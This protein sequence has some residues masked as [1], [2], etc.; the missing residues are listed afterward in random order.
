MLTNDRSLRIALWIIALSLAVIALRPLADIKDAGAQSPLEKF[1]G[2]GQQKQKGTTSSEQK[3]A[4]S[5]EQKGVPSS[6]QLGSTARIRKDC[7][8]SDRWRRLLGV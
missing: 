1:L 3:G 2:G 4:Q 5:S 8:V 7:A 6:E